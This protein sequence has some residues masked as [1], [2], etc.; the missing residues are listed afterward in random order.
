MPDGHET[1]NTESSTG[2]PSGIRPSSPSPSVSTNNDS[3]NNNTTCNP[4]SGPSVSTD[5]SNSVPG[6]NAV[7]VSIPVPKPVPV[8]DVSFSSSILVDASFSVHTQ[9]D[10]SQNIFFYTDDIACPYDDI[11]LNPVYIANI[12][13]QT[14]IDGSG[15]HIVQATGYT[16][17]GSFVTNVVFDSTDPSFNSDVELN[18]TQT[19]STYDDV[20]TPQSEN[21][22]LIS[23]IQM[24]ASE[25]K[26]SDFHGKGSIDDYTE[27]F[28]AASQIANES[29]HMELN[30]D[31]EG[32]NDFATAAD[33][34]SNL[35][36]GFII[37]LQ[38]V[39]I[40]SDSVF[41]RAVV[42]ALSKIVNLSKIF[43]QFKETIFATSSVQVPKSTHD[44]AVILHGV[45]AEINC[46]VEH[47]QYFVSPSDMSLNDA[48][49]SVEEKNMINKAVDTIHSWNVL[50]DSGVSIAMSN[51]PDIQYVKL[52]STQLK[53]TTA[54][55]NNAKT[56]LR[57]KLA[58][59]NIGC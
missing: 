59:F 43:K 9:S 1:Q 29:K 24:Y 27:L 39:N 53:Q 3:S 7:P 23:Q 21:S 42:N 48:Q 46:A 18:L 13:S 47:I 31:I 54:K 8:F 5:V 36:N 51:D 25:L 2:S 57:S 41:L 37:K 4:N 22:I 55:L 44:A 19:Y 16:T 38:N 35:F 50:C 30:I 32:F 40:I 20:S 6:S 14:I 26:C 17:D 34:L 33:D 11:S 49:L 58:N 10:F 15:Y 45:M 56:L 28:K 12:T 52:A